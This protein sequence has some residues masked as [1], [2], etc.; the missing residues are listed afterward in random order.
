MA[1]CAFCMN[2]AK[3]TGEHVN[4]DWMNKILR[5][6]WTRFF[7]SS[8]GAS[9][10]HPSAKLNWK[11]KVVCEKCN[12]GWM[13]DIESKHA[14]PVM[15][16]LI[17]GEE[18]DIPITQTDAQSI[19]IFAFKTALVVD[20]LREDEDRFFSQSVRTDFMNS[21]SIPSSV[22]MWFCAYLTRE[23]RA[24]TLAVY[25]KG[26]SRFKGFFDLY[27]CTF[28]VGCFAFQVLAVNGFAI[29]PL[30]PDRRFDYLSVPLWPNIPAGFV[31]PP[32]RNL[33]I[34][35]VD[36][37]ERFVQYHKRWEASYSLL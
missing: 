15:G 10:E 35:A 24:D 30:F 34:V 21:L 4:S 3:L 5:G 13:S 6:P 8:E 36:T 17:E 33:Q 37:Y 7:N 19:A 32:R 25:Y 9:A 11:A 12:G 27:V 29:G 31:W 28:G 14:S 23:R 2:T 22:N 16:P 18:I 20:A 26:H 1:L